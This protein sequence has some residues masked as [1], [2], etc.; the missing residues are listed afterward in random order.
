[1]AYTHL[2]AIALKLYP[3]GTALNWKECADIPIGMYL[4]ASTYQ[5]QTV[6][7]GGKV[8]FCEGG[9]LFVYKYSAMAD[10]WSTLPPAPVSWFGM[11][12][13]G[14]QLVI[15][16]GETVHN[17]V[18]GDVYTL[19][20][21]GIKWDKTTIPPMPVSCHSPA[22]FSQQS[23]LTVIGGRD[24]ED[25]VLSDMNVFL[26]GST[27][28]CK[29]PPAPC[30]LSGLTSTVINGSFFVGD[31]QSKRVLQLQV[32]VISP[33]TTTKTTSTTTKPVNGSGK[34]NEPEVTTKWWFVSHLPHSGCA[35][36]GLAGSLIAIGGLGVGTGISANNSSSSA[37]GDDDYKSLCAFSP[38][39]KTWERAGM[40]ILP[41]PLCDCITAP[42]SANELL[43]MGGR[44]PLVDSSS[45]S[46]MCCDACIK[47]YKASLLSK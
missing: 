45:S 4:P 23:C 8:Y 44:V 3:H 6:V 21:S 11:G 33:Q 28:W 37:R 42:L 27:H 32:S 9:G 25:V 20:K 26:P 39:S 35:L 1:M 38:S 41:E 30:P 47:V 2:Q 14:G 13:L 43:V 19:D 5:T 34:V 24:K 16:G 46:A 10:K 15:V 7:K 18:T 17:E 31:S 12:T 36:G 29:V 40:H 22:V